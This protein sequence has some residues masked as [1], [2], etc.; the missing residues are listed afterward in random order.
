[1]ARQGPQTQAKRRRELEKRMKRQ[2]K[3][4]K[5]EQRKAEKGASDGS[6]P[7]VIAREESLDD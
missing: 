4:E 3:E 6:G 7:P 5:R 2:R 1:M